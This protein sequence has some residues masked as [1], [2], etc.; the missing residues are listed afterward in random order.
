MTGIPSPASGW[1]QRIPHPAMD[2][3]VKQGFP[4]DRPSD[5]VRQMPHL[6]SGA[7]KAQGGPLETTQRKVLRN[8]HLGHQRRRHPVRRVAHH[9]EEKAAG[10]AVRT[11]KVPGRLSLGTCRADD[12]NDSSGW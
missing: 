6:P 11:E 2:T 10:R 3:S 12:F 9:A 4:G 7:D 8:A 1:R 5:D